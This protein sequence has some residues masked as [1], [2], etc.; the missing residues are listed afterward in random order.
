MHGI[1]AI[2][3]VICAYEYN[4]LLRF[5]T[6]IIFHDYFFKFVCILDVVHYKGSQPICCVPDVF[7]AILLLFTWS[8]F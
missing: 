8:F 7:S 2:Y 6:F 4:L 1:I 3:K 5:K